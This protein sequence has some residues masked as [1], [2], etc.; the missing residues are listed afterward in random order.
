LALLSS[1]VVSTHDDDVEAVKVVFEFTDAAVAV[2][3][4]SDTHLRFP[5]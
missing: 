4:G 1:D 3:V 5:A 2:G